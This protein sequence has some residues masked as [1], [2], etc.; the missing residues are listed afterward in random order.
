M[1]QS[2]EELSRDIAGTRRD[3]ASD[4]DALQDRVS[5]QA[6][7]ERRKAATR[8]RVRSAR[9]KVMGTAHEARGGVAG[10]ASGATDTVRDQAHGA[11][12]A[13]RKSVV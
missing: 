9:D 2:T 4:L 8:D 13:D 6:I 7:V 3:L 1:G 10:T 11:A 12:A 5:P